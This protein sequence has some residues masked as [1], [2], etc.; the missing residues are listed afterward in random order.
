MWRTV[1]RLVTPAPFQHRHQRP[2]AALVGHLHS[3][4]RSM[5]RFPQF[6]PARRAFTLYAWHTALSINARTDWAVSILSKKRSSYIKCTERFHISRCRGP[7]IPCTDTVPSLLAARS[8]HFHDTLRSFV[9]SSAHSFVRSFSVFRE[10]CL[11]SM[12]RSGEV[13]TTCLKKVVWRAHYL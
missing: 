2:L 12:N 3:L 1:D 13:S 5:T 11:S 6:S 8:F 9:P 10:G 4:V 7:A